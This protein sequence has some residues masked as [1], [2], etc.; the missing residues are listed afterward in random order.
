VTELRG[1]SGPAVDRLRTSE[2]R[3]RRVFGL[4]YYDTVTPPRHRRN[5][6]RAGLVYR[7]TLRTQPDDLQARSR[8]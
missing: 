2:K 4:G 5:V 8:R 6:W 1:M 3:S 7:L